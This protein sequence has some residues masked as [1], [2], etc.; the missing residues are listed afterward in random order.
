[1]SRH[2]KLLSNNQR[3]KD[4]HDRAITIIQQKDADPTL[5]LNADEQALVKWR[6]QKKDKRA[7]KR[8]LNPLRKWTEAEDKIILDAQKTL[9]N[10][11]VRIATL[12]ERR[13]NVDVCNRWNNSLKVC[14]YHYLLYIV[15][16]LS[17]SLTDIFVNICVINTSLDRL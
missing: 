17:L 3:N 7:Q 10:D 2:S 8:S 11:W 14:T 13:T 12:L 15:S 5:Q 16:C 6:I 1:M 9:G 4:K